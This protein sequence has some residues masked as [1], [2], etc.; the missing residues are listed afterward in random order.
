MKVKLILNLSIINIYIM[1]L[2]HLYLY[3]FKSFL[4]DLKIFNLVLPKL[5]HKYYQFIIIY[6]I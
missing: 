2:I 3:Y 5:M 1:Q 4:I 6:F